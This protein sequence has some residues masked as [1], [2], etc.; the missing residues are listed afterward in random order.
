MARSL[1]C[2]DVLPVSSG[3]GEGPATFTA[4]TIL[5]AAVLGLDV[6]RL[7]EG[8]AAMT[9][10]FRTAP[11]GDNPALDFASVCHL[12]QA[13]HGTTA[14]ELVTWNQGLTAVDA[15]IRALFREALDGQGSGAERRLAVNLIVDQPR[16]DRLVDPQSAQPLSELLAATIEQTKKSQSS[17]G[18]ASVD[19]HLPVQDESCLGQ[20]F[21]MMLL[22]S[23]VENRLQ[24][25]TAEAA[26]SLQERPIGGKE[27]SDVATPNP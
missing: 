14:C 20:L 6:M 21:Q 22:A 9:E 8:A 3:A 26:G 23:A 4:A 11:P 5:S 7:L 13:R 19:I 24:R 10:R 27:T 15:W 16:R 18:T 12:L 1:G 17:A 2:P 25:Q